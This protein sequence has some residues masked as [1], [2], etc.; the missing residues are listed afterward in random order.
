MEAGFDATPPG[1][2]L[3]LRFALL[4]FAL[5]ALWTR[6]LREGECCVCCGSIDAHLAAGAP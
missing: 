2:L 4:R 3:A 6:Q 1:A 5:Q